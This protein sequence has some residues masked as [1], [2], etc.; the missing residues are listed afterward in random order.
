MGLR[1]AFQQFFGFTRKELGAVLFLS[2]T[3]ILGLIIRWYGLFE[4]PDSGL[5]DYSREDSIFLEQSRALLDEPQDSSAPHQATKAGVPAPHSVNLNTAGHN[6]L[7]TLPGIGAA[8]ADRILRYRDANGPFRSI[9]ELER[10]KGIGKKTVSR[11]AP[12]LTL[13]SPSERPEP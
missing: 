5:F 11:L 13:T 1:S 10:V 8:Y 12:F 6:E 2:I 4:G 7:M 9:D 3:F